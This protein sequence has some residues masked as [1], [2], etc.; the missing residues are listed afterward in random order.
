MEEI[1]IEAESFNN[2]G[3]WIVE[4]QSIETIHSAY[5]MAHG[6]GIPV[7]DAYTE[8]ILNK[9]GKYNVWVLTRDWTACWGVKDSAGKFNV[10]INNITLENT[11]GTNGE[12]WAWQYAGCAVLDKGVNVI[13]LCDLT[14]FNGR[15]DAIYITD[16]DI[17]PKSDIQE[18]DNLRQRLNWKEV[19]D[20]TTEYDLIVAGGGIAGLCVAITAMRENLQVLLINDREVLGGCNSSEVRVCLAGGINIG[21]YPKL[22]DVVR[23]ISPVMGQPDR[24]DEKYFEDFRKQ[25]VFEINNQKNCNVIYNEFVSETEISNNQIKSVITINTLTGKKTRFKAKLFADCTGDAILSRAS[26]AE[27]MYGRES[28]ETFNES[29]APQKA[30]KMVMGHSIRWYST[31]GKNSGFPDLD[32]NLKFDEKTCLNVTDGDWEQECGFRR[33]MVSE[34]EY[35]RDFGL[36]AIYSNWSF[37]KNHYSKKEEYANKKLEWV[38]ACGGKRESYR[39]VGDYILTQNDIEGHVEHSDATACITWSFDFHMPEPDNDDEFEEPFR[40]YA[41]HRGIEK[42]YPIPYRCLYSKNIS[43]L[44]LGGRIISTSHVAFGA[45]RVMRTLGMLGEVVG[46]AAGICIDNDC[47][48]REVYSECLSQLKEKMKRGVE[49]PTAFT[50]DVGDEEKYH[51]KDIGWLELKP[52][53]CSTPEAIDKFIK[54]MKRANI[55]HKYE[56]PDEITDKL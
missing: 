44:F 40:S 9:E 28:R 6:M 48:P 1:F 33:N 17:A 37:Q 18:I 50:F 46:L 39:V 47:S 34:I 8:F 4:S 21:K 23:E 11:L 7:K 20:N 52:Y 49:I 31:E 43:N 25:A 29:M 53:Y 22:G 32:W 35:I 56:L 26:G 38:S 2:K 13:N 54:G 15:C 10:K 19:K 27:V 30:D 5:L 55:Q 16:S 3:G 12:E 14:G 36:R 24:F 42:A 51:Y 41:Y 45:I